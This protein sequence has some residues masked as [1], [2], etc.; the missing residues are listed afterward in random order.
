MTASATGP[1]SNTTD[2]LQ[3]PEARAAQRRAARLQARAARLGDAELDTL[4]REARSHNGWQDKPVPDAVLRELYDILSFGPTSMNCCPARFVFLRSDAA[5]ERLLPAL[6]P[7]N[8]DK[9]R[10]APVTVIIAQDSA[11]HERLPELFPHRDAAPMF[12]DNPALAADTAF[13]N[14]T[15]QGAYLIIVARALGLDCGP[16]S[17][18]DRKAVDTTFF[19]GSTLESNFLCCLGYGDTGRLFQRLPRLHVDTA[20]QFL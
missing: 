9:V 16:L 13:R 5:I 17:G 2:P 11:F 19:E 6:A 3:S 12:R 1:L 18:F 10:A 20:C 4:F 15:L 14:A 7:A 8:V